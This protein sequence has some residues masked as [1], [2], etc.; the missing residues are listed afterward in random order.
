MSPLQFAVLGFVSV[1]L[2]TL[3][4]LV[5]AVSRKPDPRGRHRRGP[6]LSAG[7]AKRRVAR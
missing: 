6:A 7:C 4:D 3:A 2:N 5:V 1:T